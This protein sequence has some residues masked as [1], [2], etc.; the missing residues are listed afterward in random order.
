MFAADSHS[1][2][3]F[4]VSRTTGA[5]TDMLISLLWMELYPNWPFLHGSLI[6][7]WGKIGP[8]VLCMNNGGGPRA[9]A[10][11]DIRQGDGRVGAYKN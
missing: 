2:D 3:A 9:K 4:S 1:I 7:N 11:K 10:S 8:I 6:Q 5:G